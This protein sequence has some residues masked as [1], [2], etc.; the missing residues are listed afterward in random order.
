MLPWK[1]FVVLDGLV[2]LPLFSFAGWSA[3][4]DPSAEGSMGG[5]VIALSA[6][7]ISVPSVTL[8]LKRKLPLLASIGLCLLYVVMLLQ[9]LFIL[10][11]KATWDEWW[12]LTIVFACLVT[13]AK[14]IG[15]ALVAAKWDQQI[16]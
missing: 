8:L 1:T 6:A 5:L 12:T 11:Y 10:M 13:V 9:G 3:F 16:R 14:S 7:L 2:S 4:T 15:L